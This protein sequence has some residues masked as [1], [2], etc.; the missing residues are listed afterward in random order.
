[1]DDSVSQAL[2]NFQNVLEVGGIIAFATSGV[3]AAGR[4]R[5]DWTGAVVLGIVAAVGGGTTR[6]LLLGEL[7]V[8][9]IEQTWFVVL[10]AVTALIVIP[11]SR[12]RV[13]RYSERYDFLSI[14]DAALEARCGRDKIYRAIRDGRLIARKFGR[15]TIIRA[16]DFDRFLDELPLLELGPAE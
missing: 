1:M 7:P 11:L 9:W 15:R 2:G 3:L 6:D 12:T 4:A 10:A 13:R 14:A 5:M 8:F 16:D